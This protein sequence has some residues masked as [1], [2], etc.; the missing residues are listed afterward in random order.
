MEGGRERIHRRRKDRRDGGD[1]G[2]RRAG[3]PSST[4]R[5]S[6]FPP[7]PLFYTLSSAPASIGYNENTRE[8]RGEEDTRDTLTVRPAGR[9]GSG[10]QAGLLHT[11]QGRLGLP[12][13]LVQTPRPRCHG[14]QSL[15]DDDDDD[16]D[17]MMMMITIIM[18][19]QYTATS[20]RCLARAAL[21]AEVASRIVRDV[22]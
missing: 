10:R 12:R 21:R 16:D 4:R 17:D 3:S 7:P 19:N 9:V 5:S 22:W 14:F 1:R 15:N 6:L 2:E 8:R 18:I 11:R 13:H 20:S